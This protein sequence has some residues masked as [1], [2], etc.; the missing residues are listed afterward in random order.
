VKPWHF[1]RRSLQSEIKFQ[2]PALTSLGDSQPWLQG[3]NTHTRDHD[4]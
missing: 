3:L 2:D 4:Q 1:I